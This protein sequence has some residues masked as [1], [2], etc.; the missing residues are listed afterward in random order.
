L[1]RK[2]SYII[3]VSLF[4]SLFVFTFSIQPAKA[5]GTIYIRADGSI[6]PPTAPIK[7]DGG[8]YKLT[9]N[10]FSDADG[11]VIE[12]NN[13]TLD[14]AGYIIRG[15][16][17][18]MT[19]GI[20]LLPGGSNITITNTIVSFFGGGIS[21]GQGSYGNVVC[22]NDLQSNNGGISLWFSFGNH[23]SEN[24]V[25]ANNNEGISLV[26]FSDNNTVL[27]N[28]IT[29]NAYDGILISH[30]SNNTISGN[31]ITSQTYM[32]ILGSGADNNSISHNII[33]GNGQ[34]GILMVNSMNNTIIDNSVRDNYNGLLFWY[35]ANNTVIS[36]N[37][38]AN[39][40][41]GIGLN[42]SSNDVFY[43]NNFIDNLNQ[44]YTNS[45][46][47]FWDNGYPSGGNYWADYTGEDLRHGAYQNETGSDG[48]GVTPRPPYSVDV[49]NLDRYP[50]SNPILGLRMTSG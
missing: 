50:S 48:I 1:R 8:L 22:G 12:R 19:S 15:P 31:I 2:A 49:N 14:G 21:L 16:G 40:F 33:F 24:N 29:G 34:A 38:T 44:A 5:I 6:D 23:I 17:N 7:R 4:L 39:N 3:V 36:N 41:Y 28:T 20:L 30:A 11:I 9:D 26:D 35:C 45:S 10:I 18:W 46:I 42:S 43:H 13:M 25:A 47:D 37:V 32:G 27:S